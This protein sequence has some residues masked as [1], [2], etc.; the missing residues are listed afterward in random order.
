MKGKH[1]Q[2]HNIDKGKKLLSMLQTA[3]NVRESNV[4]PELSKECPVIIDPVRRRRRR[5]PSIFSV[6]SQLA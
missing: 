6:V 5:R 4:T 2:Q 3:R 1:I